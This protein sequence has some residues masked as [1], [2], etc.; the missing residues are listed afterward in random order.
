[1][2]SVERAHAVVRVDVR[3]RDV[4]VSG[5]FL[6]LRGCARVGLGCCAGVFHGREVLSLSEAA[7]VTLA[8][9]G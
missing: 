2:F 3:R 5:L 7:E 9:W 8:V 1:M 6:T 4:E